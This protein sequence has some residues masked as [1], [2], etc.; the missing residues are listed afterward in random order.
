LP[1]NI[2]QAWCANKKKHMKTSANSSINNPQHL[3]NSH[4]GEREGTGQTSQKRLQTVPPD[5][6]Y[7]YEAIYGRPVRELFA[8]MY[9]QAGQ[10]VAARARILNFRTVRKSDVRKEATIIQLAAKASV[11]P[12]MH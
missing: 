10:A 3:H 12:A 1:A 6:Q 9:Q 4:A 7:R 2:R 8:G 11:N 5:I